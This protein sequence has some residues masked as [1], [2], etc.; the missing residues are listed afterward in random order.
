MQ[1]WT[2]EDARSVALAAVKKRY[3]W[4][5]EWEDIAQAAILRAIIESRRVLARGDCKPSYAAHMGALRGAFEWLHP[6]REDRIKHKVEFISLEA[7][8]KAVER[9]DVTLGEVLPA[10]DEW[11]RTSDRAALLMLAERHCTPAQREVL[12]LYLNHELSQVDIGRR[13]GLK[14]TAVHDRFKQACK[15]LRAAV[16][17]GW[18]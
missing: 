5:P 14:P 6:K 2:D 15:R 11:E 10:A 12:D 13:L 17:E 1:Q 3:S 16:P 18:N 8:V 4:H 7:L 9:E